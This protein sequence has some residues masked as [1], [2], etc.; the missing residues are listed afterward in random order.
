MAFSCERTAGQQDRPRV[1]DTMPS[2]VPIDADRDASVD[3][4]DANHHRIAAF[5]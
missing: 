3:E 1:L 2:R 5:P 4:S